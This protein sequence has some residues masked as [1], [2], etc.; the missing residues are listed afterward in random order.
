[1]DGIAIILGC[2]ILAFELE[3]IRKKLHRIADA[4]ERK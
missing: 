4:L 2:F 1:M 3:M